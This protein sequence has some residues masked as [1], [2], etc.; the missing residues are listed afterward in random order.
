[1]FLSLVIVAAVDDVGVGAVGNDNGCCRC[2]VDVEAVAVV[3][4]TIQQ[5]CLL[6]NLLLLLPLVLLLLLL[7]LS[8]VLVH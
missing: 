8:V 5:D 3:V 2:G 7:K 6:H 4:D 1:M